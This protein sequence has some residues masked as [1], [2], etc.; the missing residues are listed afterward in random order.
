MVLLFGGMGIVLG[1]AKSAK[2]QISFREVGHA[3]NM[4]YAAGRTAKCGAISVPREI[5]EIKAQSDAAAWA[6]VEE[7]GRIAADSTLAFARRVGK[8]EEQRACEILRAGMLRE[9]RI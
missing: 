7:E 3:Y 1:S 2:G 6:K 4:G 5:Q 8:A 9:W